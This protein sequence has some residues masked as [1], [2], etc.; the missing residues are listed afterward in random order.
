MSYQQSA[1]QDTETESTSRSFLERH[2]PT[3]LGTIVA[4]FI[5]NY[6]MSVPGSNQQATAPAPTPPPAASHF[7]F[8]SVDTDRNHATKICKDGV[9]KKC[10][11]TTSSCSACVRDSL[12]WC[13]RANVGDFLEVTKEC[14]HTRVVES[15]KQPHN[16]RKPQGCEAKVLHSCSLGRHCEA[17]VQTQLKLSCPRIST[18]IFYATIQECATES[19]KNH[20]QQKRHTRTNARHA[21]PKHMATKVA[22]MKKFARECTAHQGL[23]CNHCI[24][25][26][27]PLCPLANLG[28]AYTLMKRCPG[29]Q[30]RRLR[31]V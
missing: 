29:S 16:A 3:I 13:P 7:K 21:L 11:T 8:E 9:V 5:I 31:G 20:A 28:D 23:H 30:N 15:S 22:C 24:Q 2:V 25:Q 17:C 14:K 1:S 12:A 27:L 18:N 10:T 26:K 6:F 4:F 19:K